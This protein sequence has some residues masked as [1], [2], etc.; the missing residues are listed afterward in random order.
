MAK[1]PHYKG[2]NAGG[3]GNPPVKD[4]FKGKP[5]PGRPKGS[6][7]I[8]GALR[9]TFGKKVVRRGKDGKRTL[10]DAPDALAERA[11][12]LGLRGTLN[13][14]VEARKLA[15]KYGP[16][17]QSNAADL[18]KLT[19]AELHLY[20]YLTCRV[21]GVDPEDIDDK[22][23]GQLLAR[24]QQVIEDEIE[25]ANKEYWDSLRRPANQE[26]LRIESDEWD[27]DDEP[28]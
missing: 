24:V 26:S 12:E 6:K 11:L 19:D 13:A 1:S 22:E 16:Q 25:R 7:S 8:E 10:I 18:S 4:Q 20:G 3:Y 15:E 17:E 5:G 2:N 28:D 9:R 27:D 23:T 14:N 21:E